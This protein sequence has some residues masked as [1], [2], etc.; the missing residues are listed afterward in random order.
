MQI[1]RTTPLRLMIL[2]LSHIFFTLALTFIVVSPSRQNLS[3]TLTRHTKQAGYLHPGSNSLGARENYTDLSVRSGDLA[4]KRVEGPDCFTHP[5]LQLIPARHLAPA[6]KSKFDDSSESP[7]G[8]QNNQNL[9][10][11]NDTKFGNDPYRTG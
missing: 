6:T 10:R 7:N 11:G 4:A 5:T 3:V 8:I 9:N 1:T 2:H